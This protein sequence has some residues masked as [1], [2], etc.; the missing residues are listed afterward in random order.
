M[1]VLLTVRADVEVRP[2]ECQVETGKYVDI[3]CT[4]TSTDWPLWFNQS[5]TKPHAVHICSPDGHVRE[6]LENKFRVWKVKYDTFRLRVS[7][8]QPSDEGLFFCQETAEIWNTAQ[9]TLT[10]TGTLQGNQSSLDF[11]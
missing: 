10:V 1:C 6:G 9:M 11:S 3:D 4:T 5:S 7:D 2:T 8:I